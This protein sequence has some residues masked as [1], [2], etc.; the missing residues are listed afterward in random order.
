[1]TGFNQGDFNDQTSPYL[2][3][4]SFLRAHALPGAFVVGL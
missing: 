3:I 2:S 1:M 4:L